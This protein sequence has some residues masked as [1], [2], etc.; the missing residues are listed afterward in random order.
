MVGHAVHV[1]WPRVHGTLLSSQFYFVFETALK[2]S[3]LLKR[4]KE[5]DPW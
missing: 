4:E 5:R 1:L 3:L 2:N